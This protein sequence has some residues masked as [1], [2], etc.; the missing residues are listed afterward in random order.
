MPTKNQS[1]EHQQGDGR[2]W[3]AVALTRLDK[4][5]E[6]AK[7]GSQNFGLWAQIFL[8]DHVASAGSIDLRFKKELFPLRGKASKISIVCK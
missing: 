8:S 6:A 3:A 4:T 5:A 7:S 1:V 2:G